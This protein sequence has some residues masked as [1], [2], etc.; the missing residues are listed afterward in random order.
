MT[1]EQFQ[2]IA[3]LNN[4]LAVLDA[5]IKNFEKM[6]LTE[7]ELCRL[8]GENDDRKYDCC[9]LYSRPFCCRYPSISYVKLVI[10]DYNSREVEL[11]PCE[12]HTLIDAAID[13]A[14]AEKSIIL[15]EIES[16]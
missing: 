16:L 11:S 5:S 8:A 4:R 2:H 13:H 1:Q 7:Q 9:E 14:N 6:K 10:K 15:K 3:S 12:W